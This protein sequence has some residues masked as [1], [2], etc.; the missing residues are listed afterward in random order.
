[1]IDQSLWFYYLECF[2]VEFLSEDFGEIPIRVREMAV[3][4]AEE[5]AGYNYSSPYFKEELENAI[6]N[7]YDTHSII[8]AVLSNMQ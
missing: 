6:D 2:L 5:K 7:I 1:M 4:S 8:T 3:A